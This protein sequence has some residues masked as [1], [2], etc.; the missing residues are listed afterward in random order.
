MDKKNGIVDTINNIL[1]ELGHPSKSSYVALNLWEMTSGSAHITI[2]YNQTTGFLFGDAILCQL[3]QSPAHELF[4]Y[5]LT[6][7]NEA[8]KLRL[9]IRNHSI[10][11]SWTAY[12]KYFSHETGKTFIKEHLEKAD[13]LD[14]ILVNQY[15]CNWQ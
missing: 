12:D 15:G 14:N 10:I 3:P 13:W 5:L 2:A 7:N 4:A 6:Q 11:L 8:N 9:S 1:D